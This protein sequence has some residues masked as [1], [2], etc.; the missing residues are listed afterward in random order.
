MRDQRQRE[1]GAGLLIDAACEPLI[2][3]LENPAE[4]PAIVNLRMTHAGRGINMGAS[5]Q[6]RSNSP[7]RL[8][9]RLST[10]RQLLVEAIHH[11][12]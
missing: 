8:Q 12:R 3:A 1:P 9:W 6:L 10:R 4:K 7:Q 5:Q 2:A 11:H